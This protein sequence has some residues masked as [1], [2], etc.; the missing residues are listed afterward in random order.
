LGGA[1]SDLDVD[2]FGA[3]DA[4]VGGTEP[5]GREKR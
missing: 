4:A 1:P 3:T 2:E 5:V